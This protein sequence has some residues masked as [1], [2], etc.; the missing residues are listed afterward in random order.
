[1]GIA[2][3]AEIKSTEHNANTASSNTNA[4]GSPTS[5]DIKATQIMEDH[6]SEVWRVQWNVTGTSLG[7][8]GDDGTVRIWKQNTSKVGNAPRWILDGVI[9]GSK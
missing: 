8:S 2:N 7:S 5:K 4:E 1:M 9:A 3:D 6:Q